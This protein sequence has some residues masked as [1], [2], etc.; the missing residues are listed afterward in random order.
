MFS[1]PTDRPTPKGLHYEKLAT[2]GD[3]SGIFSR[4]PVETAGVEPGVSLAEPE[5]VQE[6]AKSAGLEEATPIEP[7]TP[8]Q[9]AA[10]NLARGLGREIVLVSSPSEARNSGMIDEQGRMFVHAEAASPLGV[11]AHELAHDLRDRLGE[12]G[13]RAELEN[14][15]RIAPGFVDRYTRRWRRIAD[16]SQVDINNPDLAVEEGFASL[17]EEYAALVSYAS[18]PQGARDLAVVAQSSPTIFR[19]LIDGVRRLVGKV[20]PEGTTAAL[21]RIETAT[22]QRPDQAA[23]Q[24]SSYLADLYQ[25][26]LAVDPN[27]SGQ[28]EVQSVQPTAQVASPTQASQGSLEEASSARRAPRTVAA[29]AILQAP[30]TAAPAAPI[31]SQSGEALASS[32]PPSDTSAPET[33]TSRDTAEN[34]PDIPRPDLNNPLD[35]AE[36]R[37]VLDAVDGAR[38][39]QGLP[40][41]VSIAE[42]R[43]FAEE[44]LQRDYDG[45]RSEIEAKLETGELLSA[46]ETHAAV[47][48]LNGLTFDGLRGVDGAMADAVRLGEAYRAVRS[49]TAR[50]LGTT[51]GRGQSAQERVI[52]MLTLPTRSNLRK[53][54]K[55][56]K[57]V[58]GIMRLV[59]PF[60]SDRARFLRTRHQD[61]QERRGKRF[62]P[63][64]ELKFAPGTLDEAGKPLTE[65]RLEFLTKKLE[66]IEADEARRMEK[67]GQALRNMG[68]DIDALSVE[69]ILDP[70]DGWKIRNVISVAKSTKTDKLLEYR[71]MSML[72]GVK[73]HVA[74]MTGNAAQLFLEGP[75]QKAAEGVVNLFVRDERSASIGELQWWFRGFLG[76]VRPAF[77]NLVNAYRTEGPAWELDLER[78]GVEMGDYGS[79]LGSR[80][81]FVPGPKIGSRVAR[82]LRHLSLNTLQAGDEFIK[83]IAGTAEL[84]SLAYREASAEGL[85]GKER[86]VRALALMDD[87]SSNIWTQS[88]YKARQVTFQDEGGRGSQFASEIVGNLVGGLDNIGETYTRVPVG[89]V[90]IPFRRT[91]I[92]IAATALR[93]SPLQSAMIPM[94][95]ISGEYRGKKDALVRDLADA[96]V[97]WGLT[98]AIW[99]LVSLEDDE[100]LPF[101]TGSRSDNAGENALSFRNAPPMSIRLDGEYHDYGRIEPFATS[102]GLLV[103]MVQKYE[104]EGTM[105]SFQGL[106]AAAADQSKDKTFLRNIGEI[107]EL[108]DSRRAGKDRIAKFMRDTLVTPLVPNIIRQIARES[109][110]VLRERRTREQGELAF[111]LDGIMSTSADPL[112]KLAGSEPR[113]QRYDAWGRVIKR[114]HARRGGTDLIFRLLNPL[115]PR[116]SVDDVSRIDLALLNWKTRVTQGE[117]EDGKPYFIGRPSSRF[118]I[119][120]QS[121]TMTPSEYDSYVRTSGQAAAKAIL[122]DTEINLDEPSQADIDRIRKHVNKQRREARDKVKEQRMA[123]Q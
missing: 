2:A 47:D 77:R 72:S 48:I 80:L 23:A 85:R 61:E 106:M 104:Q 103:G 46:W 78:R 98:M 116:Q 60:K 50:A 75:A 25:R 20:D 26:T 39:S 119:D 67:A 3:T 81:D 13:F 10:V 54:R 65:A 14:V 123:A 114:P 69:D 34:L 64:R 110:D 40:A 55:I 6:F 93:R 107:M 74:N 28:I 56:Q 21:D 15:E 97:A 95:A 87:T 35:S 8:D 11:A 53:R 70:N 24:L 27:A 89:T 109:D 108:A 94:K 122:A 51:R 33:I 19:R 43:A 96:V 41:P 44:Q 36:G 30:N 88:L 71:Y 29:S 58:D 84:W 5:S 120:K 12:D 68:F 52:D 45:T 91:P 100:G 111:W 32:L 7:Q 17:V 83:T 9:A 112:A 16:T 38:S 113:R 18:Q 118:I 102:V 86:E 99:E 63:N 49:E 22:R 62:A 57:E 37:A 82:G 101:I 66:E 73:T 79:A 92:R 31:S 76:S 4:P 115:P 105:E 121:F 42:Q 90:L 1:F 117:V 59:S